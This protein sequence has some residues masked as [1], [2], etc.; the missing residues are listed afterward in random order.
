MEGLLTLTFIRNVP[1]KGKYAGDTT[2]MT[3]QEYKAL[4]ALK[5]DKN[6]RDKKPVPLDYR[7]NHTEITGG[8]ELL[9]ALMTEAECRAELKNAGVKVSDKAKIEE[10]HEL[11]KENC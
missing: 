7:L 1:D 5:H 2:T 10:L 4:S 6:K 9:I 11:V 8:K 3:P